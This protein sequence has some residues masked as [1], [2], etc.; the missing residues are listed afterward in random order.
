MLAPQES[1]TAQRIMGDLQRASG[2]LGER[3][4]FPQRQILRPQMFPKAGDELAA[5][6]RL[7]GRASASGRSALRCGGIEDAAPSGRN[8][9]GLN[10]TFLAIFRHRDL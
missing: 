7:T 6:F 8:P 10:D 5:V 1:G 4:I 3:V 2:T 9:Q